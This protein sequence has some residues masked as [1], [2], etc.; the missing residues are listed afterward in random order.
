MRW[1][2]LLSPSA[3]A[4]IGYLILLGLAEIL[5]TF[6][7]PLYGLIL[8]CLVLAALLI[9]SSLVNRLSE[10]SFLLALTLAPL[11]R[12]TQS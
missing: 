3:W 8:H 12:T 7:A 5:V 9:H 11:I 10:R 6:G 4:A 1:L 2:K